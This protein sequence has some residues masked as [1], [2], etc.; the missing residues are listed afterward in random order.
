M[1]GKILLGTTQDGSR[2]RED[3]LF[4]YAD[5]KEETAVSPVVS[6]IHGHPDEGL[7]REIP[8]MEADIYNCKM[9]PEIQSYVYFPMSGNIYKVC[10]NGAQKVSNYRGWKVK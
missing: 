7:D 9:T 6:K 2:I 4:Q 1:F 8:S 10:G 3:V 5:R